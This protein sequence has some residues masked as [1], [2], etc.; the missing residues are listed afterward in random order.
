MKEMDTSLT[1]NVLMLLGTR[2]FHP[3]RGDTLMLSILINDSVCAVCR[4]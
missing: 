4:C 1:L 3:L 2:N